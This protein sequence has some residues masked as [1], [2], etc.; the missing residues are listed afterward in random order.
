MPAVDRPE[1]STKTARFS[2]EK[3]EELVDQ[4]ANVDVSEG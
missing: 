2:D 1:P 3:D 4:G